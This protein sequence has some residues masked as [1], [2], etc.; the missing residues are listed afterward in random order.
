VPDVPTIAE[1][2][3]PGFDSTSWQGLFV[4]AAT[5]K[6]IVQ[7]LSQ[8]AVKALR[9]PEVLQKL[10]ALGQEP[11]GSTP[12]QFEQQFRSDVAKFVKIV[13]EARIPAQD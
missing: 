12:E 1:Q 11:V 5:P 4:P 3:Y 2:G 13:R 8:E 6:D 7:R 9:A 10:P